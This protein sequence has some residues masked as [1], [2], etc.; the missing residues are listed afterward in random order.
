MKRFKDETLN[1]EC[2]DNGEQAQDKEHVG[3]NETKIMQFNQ[4]VNKAKETLD[5][6]KEFGVFEQINETLAYWPVDHLSHEQLVTLAN[7]TIVQDQLKNILK[8]GSLCD[9]TVDRI[10][11]A[12]I[13]PEPLKSAILEYDVQ[14]FKKG[15]YG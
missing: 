14:F 6:L 7:E 11:S 12:S 4:T 9:S 15:K 2:L 3:N 13:N 1:N 5:I 10:L 8:T